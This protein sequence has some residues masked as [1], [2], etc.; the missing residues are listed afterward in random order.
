MLNGE[1]RR[2]G[3]RQMPA[4]T[5]LVSALIQVQAPTVLGLL[6]RLNTTCRCSSVRGLSLTHA[7]SSE[8]F[9]A[10]AALLT[11]MC[12]SFVTSSGTS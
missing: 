11:S 9:I 5:N 6:G 2:A 12:G 8:V 10:C 4:M 1:L 3:P 7:C